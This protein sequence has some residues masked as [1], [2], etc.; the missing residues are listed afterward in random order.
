MGFEEAGDLDGDLFAAARGALNLGDLADVGT[1]RDGDAAKELNAF[2]NGV[3]EFDLLFKVLVEEKMELVEGG[4][5][6]LPVVFFVH[7][8]DLDGV[9]EELVEHL[10][11]V[12][13]DL[14]VEI[15]GHILDDFAVL[16]NFLGLGVPLGG[17]VDLGYLLLDCDCHLL[18]PLEC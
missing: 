1:H 11:H 17:C 12:G 5:G 6:D 7:V 3:N 13:A 4:S 2:R 14:G 8:A 9:C 18:P 16:L 10:A 15:V